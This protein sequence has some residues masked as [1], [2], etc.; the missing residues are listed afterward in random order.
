MSLLYLCRH[1]LKQLK[2]KFIW[3]NCI[4][5]NFFFGV[6][7]YGG[8]FIFQVVFRIS[9]I[10]I[11]ERAV[12]IQPANNINC[13]GFFLNL[14]DLI[15]WLH[16]YQVRVFVWCLKQKYLQKLPENVTISRWKTKNIWNT[17]VLCY[18]LAKHEILH[19]TVHCVCISDC[20]NDRVSVVA[21]SSVLIK[22]YSLEIE[23][24]FKK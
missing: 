14:K 2:N 8:L 20:L 21:Y 5:I 16:D 4:Q 7:K 22:L 12:I 15:D 9:Q 24:N 6:G 23:F 1:Y 17:A 19:I 13:W 10:L 3:R 18:L 11:N